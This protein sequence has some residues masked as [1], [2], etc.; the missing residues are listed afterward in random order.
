MSTYTPDRWTIIEFKGANVT[1]GR[2]YKVL[3]SWKGGFATG[4]SWRLNS[5]ITEVI[6]MDQ[7]YIIKGHSGSS[8]HCY[9]GCEG[10]FMYTRGILENWLAQGTDQLSIVEVTIEDVIKGL[11]KE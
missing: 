11:K 3:G 1:D 2:M 8:Y 4:D 10:T 7:Y 9:K 6:D 5:G